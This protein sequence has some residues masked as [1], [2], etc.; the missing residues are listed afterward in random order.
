ML[1]GTRLVLQRP[2]FALVFIALL[3]LG[4]CQDGERLDPYRVMEGERIY[5]A[6]CI[7]CH[8]AQLQGDGKRP[9]TALDAGRE[10][11]QWTRAE[12][13]SRVRL[14]VAGDASIEAVDDAMPGFGRKLNERQVESVLTYIESQWPA[15]VLTGRVQ[16][17][18]R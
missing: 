3:V 17:A 6:E 1:C 16:Q 5:K 4:G 10:P 13:A 7:T 9:Q 14:G 12:L 15:D 11:W 2:A 8:G 18:W